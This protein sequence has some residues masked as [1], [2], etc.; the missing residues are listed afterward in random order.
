MF[1]LWLSVASVQLIADA[2][3]SAT[4]YRSQF[5]VRH[6]GILLNDLQLKMVCRSNDSTFVYVLQPPFICTIPPDQS[7]N[8][9]NTVKTMKT[10]LMAAGLC[11][12]FVAPVHAGDPVAGKA[13]SGTCVACHGANG[14]SPTDIWPNL[15]GQKAGY[16]AKQIRAFKDGTRKDPQM[17]A[18]VAALTDKQID[19]L[20]AYFASLK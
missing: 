12:M 5:D 9:G 16:L 10:A 2:E 7:G 17:N 13:A 18:M 19:D 1:S 20:A 4:I 14:I 11:A 6:R 15:A 8:G 3:A